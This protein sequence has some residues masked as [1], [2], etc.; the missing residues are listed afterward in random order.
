MKDKRQ[1]YKDKVIKRTAEG[2]SLSICHVEG[3]N[4]DS[5]G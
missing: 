2:K 4:T 5:T 3:P 1:K